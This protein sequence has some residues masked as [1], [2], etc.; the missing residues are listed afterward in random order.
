[1]KEEGKFSHIASEL[2]ELLRKRTQEG[3]GGISVEDIADCVGKEGKANC[4]A[5]KERRSWIR[6]RTEKKPAEECHDTAFFISIEGVAAIGRE[7]LDFWRMME[8]FK[9]HMREKCFGR[10]KH[11]VMISN[12]WALENY[13]EY[14]IYIEQLKKSGV[15]VEAYFISKYGSILIDI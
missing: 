5:S 2:S 1:M 9:E 12:T 15:T 8:K 10:T 4:Y 13:E 11:A 14:H 3:G 7:H 6:E